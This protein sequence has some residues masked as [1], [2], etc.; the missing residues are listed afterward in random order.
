MNV[1]PKIRLIKTG[2][3]DLDDVIGGFYEGQIILVEG[4][5]G[6]GKTLFVARLAYESLRR[7]ETVAWISTIERLNEF[8]EFMGSIGLD[9]R[10]YAAKGLFEFIELMSI[11][12]EE[13]GANLA[14]IVTDS[15][16]TYNAKLIILDTIDPFISTLSPL[17]LFTIVR[18]LI[19]DA[20]LRS[21][22]LFIVIHELRKREEEDH[23]MLRAW[24][25]AVLRFNLEVPGMGAPRRFLEILK[26]RGR[27]IGR[28][29]Y[30]VDIFPDKGIE[31]YPTGVLEIPESKISLEEKLPTRIEGLDKI[32]NGGFIR[33]TSILIT[34]PTGSGKTILTLSMAANW[35]LNGYRAYFISFEE[36]YQQVVETLRFLGYNVDEL[37]GKKLIIKS[38]NPRTITITSF[39]NIVL[40]DL[41][42]DEKTVVVIDG[43]HS[44]RKEFG[45]IFHRHV[46]DLV[47]YC[48]KHGATIILSMIYI[49]TIEKGTITWL[50]TIVDGIIE[51]I[52]RREDLLLKRY[53][54]I[55]KMRMA[56]VEPKLYEFKLV[57]RRIK[58]IV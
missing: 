43:L 21:G 28:V 39:F 42:I 57:D 27:P 29:V 55:R 44:I 3:K 19:K 36:P 34:G 20:I 51:L 6:T 4:T 15:I 25:D 37:V 47:M 16:K 45:E 9:F 48:K 14:S 23:H 18:S 5:P 17:E 10:K 32:L 22:S 12:R 33:G 1:H 58:V 38:I 26:I 35:A 50:S 54:L 41:V 52:M 56:E 46:R 40:R 13:A 30:E 2:I 11:S 7:G 53:V 8:M 31:I 49:E 24:A